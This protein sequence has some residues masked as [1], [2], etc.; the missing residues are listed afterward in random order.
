[1]PSILRRLRALKARIVAAIEDVPDPDGDCGVVVIFFC[2][3]AEAAKRFPAALNAAGTCV[4]S[5]LR[6]LRGI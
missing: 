2:P 5:S 3:T 4:D 6:K 1:M